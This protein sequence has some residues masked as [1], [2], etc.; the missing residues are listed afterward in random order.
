MRFTDLSCK[1]AESLVG[2][3]PGFFRCRP[4]GTE[5]IGNFRNHIGGRS[6][7]NLCDGEN[8]GIKSRHPPGDKCLKRLDDLAGNWNRVQAI[9][10]HRG[11]STLAPNCHFKGI[12]CC[13]QRPRSPCE[14]TGIQQWGNVQRKYG[15][16]GIRCFKQPLFQ[17]FT[18]AIKTFFPGLEK[19]IDAASQFVLMLFQYFRST[20][21]HRRVGIVS[22]SV[23]DP[24]GF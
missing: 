9:V 6:R 15:I 3:R 16:R 1:P 24:G 5:H 22:A 18:S 17:H 11:V 14:D 8:D 21:E 2:K 20:H 7:L 4:D 19:E 10:W 12:C 23:H 13:K